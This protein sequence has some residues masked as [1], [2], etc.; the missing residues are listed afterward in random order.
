MDDTSPVEV[1]DDGVGGAD[2]A[3]GSGLCGLEARVQALG[4]RLDIC[5]PPSGGTIV[6]AV[7]PCSS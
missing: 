4:E 3:R 2:A 7:L 5:S 6:R 1:A